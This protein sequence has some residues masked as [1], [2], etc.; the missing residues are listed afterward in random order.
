MNLK[1][2]VWAGTRT[3]HSEAM[4]A[5]VEGVLGLSVRQRH[6]TFTVYELPNGDQLEVFG[7][8]DREHDFLSDPAIGFLVDDVRAARAEMERKGVEFIGEI[9]TGASGNSWSHFRAPDGHVYEITSRARP[10]A[11]PAE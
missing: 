7:P 3:S 4:R 5:F 1:G 11:A 8:E 2:I 10:G 9:H 6:P